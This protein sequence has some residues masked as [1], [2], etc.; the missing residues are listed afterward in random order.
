M[1]LPTS[2]LPVNAILSTSGCAVSA[3]PVS[4]C[5]VTMLTTPGGSP[6]VLEVPRQLEDRER[7]L[8]GRLE[9]H[10]AAGAD[11]RRNLP[12]GHEERIV[13]RNDL[14][15]DADRLAQREAQRVVRNG[16]DVAVDLRGEAAVVLEAGGD[17]GD[18]ELRLDDWLSVV[19]RLQLGELGRVVAN[20]LGEA[21]Q[22]AAALCAVVSFH[23][24]D[25]KA[26]RAAP[27]RA[28]D[29][30]RRRHRERGR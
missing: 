16:H 26:R 23:G 10:R 21:K 6:A 15:A 9:D 1:A 18:V 28:V 27:D 24:A 5:P 29:V 11:R 4:P 8:L 13:P 30:G 17:V 2:A 7:R 20:D 19:D 12:R 25:S 3:A 22:N 14:P